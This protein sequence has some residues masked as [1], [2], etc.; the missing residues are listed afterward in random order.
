MKIEKCKLQDG[1]DAAN[2]MQTSKSASRAPS[3]GG[4]GRGE[5]GR[6]PLQSLSRVSQA[7]LS[8]TTFKP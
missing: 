7:I 4:E 3:P 6:L 5:G 2:G 1:R 8:L